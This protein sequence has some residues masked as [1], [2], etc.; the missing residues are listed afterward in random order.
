MTRFDVNG[1]P[2]EVA[3]VC[4]IGQLSGNIP[5]Y[6]IRTE[7]GRE[8][9]SKA[10]SMIKI[11]SE[12]RDRIRLTARKEAA[13]AP[14]GLSFK[15]HAEAQAASTED[16]EKNAL[17]EAKRASL[18]DLTSRIDSEEMCTKEGYLEAQR[19]IV[20]DTAMVD[21]QPKTGPVQMGVGRDH[22]FERACRASAELALQV[23]AAEADEERNL[24][25]DFQVRVL[26]R[27][28]RAW[29]ANVRAEGLT[30]DR[31]EGLM[32][33]V[34]RQL[35]RSFRRKQKQDAAVMKHSPTRQPESR[36]V[37]IPSPADLE[38]VE[39]LTSTSIEHGG[40][41]A[42]QKADKVRYPVH[43]NCSC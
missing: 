42:I 5:S 12:K 15:M 19:K 43:C 29:Q 9:Y 23:S 7:D 21:P 24:I 16:Q 41:P 1:D 13:A 35:Q 11:Y 18:D 22:Q 6:T 28:M 30:R 26:Q 37:P 25:R 8:V 4:R 14:P 27:S 33:R 10:G 32:E 40:K 34:V 2:Y 31:N 38:G 3:T 36:K 39:R 17:E 20:L